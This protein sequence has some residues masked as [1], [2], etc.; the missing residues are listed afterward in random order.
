LA[1]SFSIT[2]LKNM[3]KR[4]LL[5]AGIFILLAQ[6]VLAQ[7]VEVSGRVADDKGDPIA[8]VSVTEKNNTRNGTTT[9]A[10]GRYKLQV[11]QGATL[12]FSS[13]GFTTREVAAADAAN[14]SLATAS[15]AISEVV[16]TSFGIRREKKALG[17]AVATVDAKS[18]E[19]RPESDV[20]RLLNGKAPGVDIL[21]ASGMSGSGTNIIIRGVST[22]TGSST[23]LFV[24]DGVP[25]DASTNAQAS[26]QYGNTTS[27]RF[28]DLDP[29]NIDNISVLKGLSATVLYGELGRNGVILITTKTGSNKKANN[30]TEVTLTQSVFINEVANLP[31]YQQSYGGGF[32]Q[33]VGLAFFSNWGARFTDPPRLVNHPYDRAALNVALPQF[34]PTPGP[35]NDAIYEYKPYNSVERFFRKGVIKTTSVGIQ[36]GGPNGSFSANYSYTDDEGFT[37]GNYLFKNNFG[38]GGTVKLSNKINLSGTFNYAIT[39]FKAP[40]TST[41]FG[42]NPT[43][44]SVFGNLIYTPI[45]VNLMGGP[46]DGNNYLPWENPLDR[47]SIYYRSNNDIQNPRWTV[48]NSFTGQKVN[49]MYGNIRLS[50]ELFPDVNVSYRLGYD[51]YND[52]NFLKQNKGGTVG[53]DLIYRR[54]IYRTVNGRNTIWDHSILAEWSKKLNGGWRVNVDAGANSQDRSYIQDGQRSTQ[55]LVYGLFDHSNFIVHDNFDEG[56]GDLDG[57]ERRLAIG[58]FAQG[59]IAY[60]EYVYLTVGGRNS[61]TSNLENNNRSL[62]YPSASLSFI[63]TLAFESLKGSKMVNYLK[64]RGGYS[65]SANFGSPYGTR[66][67]LN[68][69]TN[70]F[71]DRVGTI[72]N[73]NSISNR[74][75]NPDLKPELI[76]E[77]ELGIEGKFINNRVNLDLTFYRRLSEDQIL[78]RDL[79]PSTGFSVT[80]INA[81]NVQNKGIEMGLGVTPVRNKDWRWQLDGNF[82]L[83]RSKVSK[84]PDDIKQIPI[85]G[86]SN[87]GLFAI[88]GQPLG[89]IQ[90]NYVVKVDPKTGLPTGD[91]LKGTR[92]VSPNGDYVASTEI[93]IIGDPTPDFKLSGISTLDYKGFSFRMQWDWTQGGDMLAYTP[94]TLVGRGLTKDTDFDRLLP[95]ILPGVQGDGSPNTVQISASQAYFNNYSGFFSLQDLITY[96]ATVIRLREASLSYSIPATVL[97]KT[98]LG[99]L[100]LTIS[101]Q[102]L[103]YNAPNFPKYTNFDPET[104]SLGVSNV[105]GLEY[106]SGPTSRRIGVSLRATF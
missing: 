55:Q 89:I 66:P 28:L 86:F 52:Y 48:A 93:G 7:T 106:L 13:I 62:F 51:F 84:L 104:S 43:V 32:D 90:A 80:R 37:P 77:I 46:E 59:T 8:G 70:V 27:S 56:G 82:T 97:K 35:G 30:K 10:D 26:F 40:P 65:T 91:P 29:N 95:L 96:D 23:P 57:Q 5:L 78:D 1:T 36:T 20:V 64:I 31:E 60:N 17:Y 73:T 14:V 101:G 45:A 53:A 75:P 38:L 74:L 47:S 88:N 9:G 11:K 71:E 25:F 34:N 105:R 83:N 63:P 85:D 12:I 98:P 4:L 76:G 33:S 39:D 24:V 41:S 94:G 3:R 79:D 44:S 100:S 72:I 81:G 2:K 68:I 54:G 102:N 69:S 6:T 58:I 19:Q 50:Y 49:R 22:I 21:N 16:V 103:W 15:A 61:W 42:S 67:I 18:L 99:S 92:L 87:E